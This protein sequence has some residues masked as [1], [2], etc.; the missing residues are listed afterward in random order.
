MPKTKRDSQLACLKRY[1]VMAYT[2]GIGLVLL[3]FV[4]MPLQFIW[5]HPGFEQVVGTLHGFLYMLYLV[6]AGELWYRSR[7]SLPRLLAVVSAGLLP[8]MAFVVERRISRKAYEEMRDTTLLD[9]FSSRQS[10]TAG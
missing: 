4:G 7:W 6:V 5:H 2:V 10:P 3:V 8:F 9:R 1:R